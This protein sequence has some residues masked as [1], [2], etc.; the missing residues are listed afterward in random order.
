MNWTENAVDDL[1]AVVGSKIREA[2]KRRR[3]NQSDL[4]TDV[5]LTRSSIAN[6]EAG[7]QR[8]LVHALLKVAVALEVP[9]E[10]LLPSTDELRHEPHHD[11]DPP[12][13]S[14]QSH[15]TQ[16]FVAAALRQARKGTR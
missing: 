6:V 16:D 13:L 15:S 9:P 11:H 14:G 5:G 12:D 4:A 3:W 10:S 2:R 8:L 1:Y 7:R